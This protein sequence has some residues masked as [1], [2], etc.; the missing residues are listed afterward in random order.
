MPRDHNDDI[1]ENLRIF[2]LEDADDSGEDVDDLEEDAYELFAAS[3]G[4]GFEAALDAIREDTVEPVMLAGFSGMDRNQVRQLRPVWAALPDEARRTIADHV[5]MLG[6]DD[7]L[8][9]FQ[10]FY[11]LMIDDPLPEVREAGANG[12]AMDEDEDLIEPLLRLMARDPETRVRVA[13]AHALATYT[14][15]GEFMELPDTIVRQMRNALMRIVSADALSPELR[16]A[17]LA[18]AAVQSGDK[19]IEQAVEQFAKSDDSELQ[20]GAYQAMGRSGSKIWIKR[21]DA[22][23]R[24][25]DPEIRGQVARSLGAFEDEVIPILTMLVREDT[26]ASVRADAIEALGRVGGKRALDALEKLR[27]FVS[28]DQREMVDDAIEEAREWAVLEDLD[29][30]YEDDPDLDLW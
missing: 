25:D 16:A 22:A 23:S 9:D 15:L 1:D 20:L 19:E 18:S 24:S 8:R 14:T 12:L 17:A 3:S 7:V 5:L 26:E 11:R 29:A 10:R 27:P 28:D 30:A 13:A 6:M 4:P 21:L 2:S